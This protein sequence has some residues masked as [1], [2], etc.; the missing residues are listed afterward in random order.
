M[1]K[2]KGERKRNRKKKERMEDFLKKTMGI[3]R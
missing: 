2:R 3:S 1:K